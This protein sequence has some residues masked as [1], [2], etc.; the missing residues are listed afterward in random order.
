MLP[1]PVYA[2]VQL[3]NFSCPAVS[4]S[5]SR[6]TSS[7]RRTLTSLKSTPAA[8]TQQGVLFDISQQSALLCV[9]VMCVYVNVCARAFTFDCM[10][11]GTE[12]S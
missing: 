8:C 5:F 10:H 1:V 3:T 6:V 2:Y 9:R 7:P 12:L 4:Q 11:D